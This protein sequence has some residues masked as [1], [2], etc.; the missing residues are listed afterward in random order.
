MTNEKPK[1]AKP[2]VNQDGVSS[3]RSSLGDPHFLQP[4]EGVSPG[5]VV[6]WTDPPIVASI[7]QIATDP[8]E[9][10]EREYRAFEALRRVLPQSNLESPGLWVSIESQRRIFHD[11]KAQELH[12]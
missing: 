10:G 1:Q 3:S 8:L 7:H 9:S 6:I 11:P 5:E 12:S 4:D 2:A